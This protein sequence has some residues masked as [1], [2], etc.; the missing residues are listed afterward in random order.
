MS[1]VI[2]SPYCELCKFLHLSSWPIIS[3]LR[4]VVRVSIS[5]REQSWQWVMGHIHYHI[6]MGHR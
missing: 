2:V 5:L 6:Q 4:V 1:F 3:G